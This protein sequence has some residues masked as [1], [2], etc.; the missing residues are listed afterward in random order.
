MSDLNG[1]T[2]NLGL[3]YDSWKEFEK[4]KEKF[5]KEFFEKATKE[6][7]KDVAEKLA[8]W[9][10]PCE[11]SEARKQ[12]LKYNPGWLVMAI[13]TAFFQVNDERIPGWEAVIEEDPAFKAFV[14]VNETDER[15]YKR[16]VAQ[17]PL[18]L[19]DERME[20]ED[21]ELLSEVSFVLPWGD[22]VLMSLE[23]LNPQTTAAVAPYLY[24]GK[25][26]VKLDA[27]RKAKPED[28]E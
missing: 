20:V 2:A 5:R 3:A 11:E 27:P 10:S 16:S 4:H 7:A 18:L 26:K 19:D 9:Y 28:L 21:P 6:C 17:G 23:T 8:Q 13:R 22:R 24:R 12:I 25:P 1:I 14:Y 15:V